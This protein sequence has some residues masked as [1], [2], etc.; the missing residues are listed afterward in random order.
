M[1]S[2]KLKHPSGRKTSSSLRDEGGG[3]LHCAPEIP[4]K[5]YPGMIGVLA[6]FLPSFTGLH[7]SGFFFQ[8]VSYYIFSGLLV[9]FALPVENDNQFSWESGSMCGLNWAV[10]DRRQ[11]LTETQRI[12]V[13]F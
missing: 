8:L 2:G 13:S 4:I 7:H 3:N 1:C 5:D 9:F 6:Y 11:V 10:I 12:F